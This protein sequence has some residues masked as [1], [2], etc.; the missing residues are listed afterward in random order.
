MKVC[1]CV[2]GEGREMPKPILLERNFMHNSDAV[3]NYNHIFG[4]TKASVTHHSD[5]HTFSQTLP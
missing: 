5:T 2:F 1:V 4:P 3:S